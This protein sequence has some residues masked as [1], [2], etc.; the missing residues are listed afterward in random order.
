ML[1]FFSLP[2]LCACLLFAC[3]SSVWQCAFHGTNI[4]A[5]KLKMQINE[6]VN[7][8]GHQ[9]E[10]SAIRPRRGTHRGSDC[11]SSPSHGGGNPLPTSTAW[12]LPS[13]IYPIP[14]VY[15]LTWWPLDASD[16]R[17]NW[18]SPATFPSYCPAPNTNAVRPCRPPDK[19]CE[20]RFL[21]RIWSPCSW[22]RSE[23]VTNSLIA[24]PYKSPKVHPP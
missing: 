2:Q 14:Y 9:I 21:W 20:W 12:I 6:S 8:D 11:Q 10:V 24:I 23:I 22:C 15:T 18:I 4:Y 5:N 17:I 7:V 16:N 3:V 19:D 1:K 13:T